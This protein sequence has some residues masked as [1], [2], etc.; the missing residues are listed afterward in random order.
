MT[1][2]PLLARLRNHHEQAQNAPKL[3]QRAPHIGVETGTSDTVG[4]AP[5]PCEG[6]LSPMP[7]MRFGAP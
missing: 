1:N 5:P 7:R 6:W 4:Y 2:L 3:G